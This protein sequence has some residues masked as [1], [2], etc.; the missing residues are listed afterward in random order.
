MSIKD[1]KVALICCGRLENRYAIEFIEYYKE[2]GFD[3]IY[4]IDNNHDGEEYFE[5][6]LQFLIDKNFVTIYNYRNLEAI[7]WHA[8]KEIYEKINNKYDFVF[9]CD[10]DE[11]LTLVKDIN[12]KEYLTR[13]CFNNYN[14]ILINWKIYSDN[15]L[16]YDDG[17][18]CLERFLVESTYSGWKN[19]LVKPFLR[20]N[21][22]DIYLPGTVHI[23]KDNNS[24]LDST[25]CN[26]CG[27]KTE[28]HK[29]GCIYPN[30]ELAYI[31]HF[32]TKTIDEYVHKK[33]KRGTADMFYEDFLKKSDLI[34][35]FF[36]INNKTKEKIHYLKKNFK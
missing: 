7:Q 27:I 34:D 13:N 28:L 16:I 1:I 22:K 26:N 19:G 15:D 32:T 29:S 11:F 20:S 30:Y 21:I 24:I 12:I 14:Q 10:F 9:F 2:L 25:S 33:I 17:R 3:H 8:Y 23:F 18:G 5:D 36:E 31:K 6:I 4:I 35:Y